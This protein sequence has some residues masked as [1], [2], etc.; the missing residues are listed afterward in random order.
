MG[1][2]IALGTTA[3]MKKKSYILMHNACTMQDAEHNRGQAMKDHL[4]VAWISIVAAWR[5]SLPILAGLAGVALYRRKGKTLA[6][7]V[8]VIGVLAMAAYQF[9]HYR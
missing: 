8:L 7:L 6:L 2:K 1:V 3:R 9:E 5:F 4:I